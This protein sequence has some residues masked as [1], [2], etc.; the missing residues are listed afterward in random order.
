MTWPDDTWQV[1]DFM[2]HDLKQLMAA[3]KQ[4]FTEAEVNRLLRPTSCSL[5]AAPSSCLPYL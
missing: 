5:P 2:D 1:M 4:P 3:M